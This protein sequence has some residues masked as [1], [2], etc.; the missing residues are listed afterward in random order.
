[1]LVVAYL[2]NTKWC[3]KPE[4]WLE[5]LHMGTHLRVLIWEYSARSFQW[6]PTWQGLKRFQES[7]RPCAL[8]ESS[9]SSVKVNTFIPRLPCHRYKEQI[10]LKTY[11]VWWGR[12][13][14]YPF[15]TFIPRSPCHRYKG[16]IPLK[17]H[18][19]WGGRGASHYLKT[20]IPRSPCHRY[21]RT[22]KFTRVPCIANFGVLRHSVSLY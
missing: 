16:Q 3:K 17:T 1:M 11:P 9:L 14:S 10:P 12:G 13:A 8:N 7:L 20:Y 5:T 21:C 22:W 4:K 2:A 15:N 18:P 19:V 6:I